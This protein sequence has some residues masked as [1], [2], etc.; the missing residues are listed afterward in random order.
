MI[1]KHAKNLRF[2]QNVKT[3][4]LKK[5]L[6]VSQAA[7]SIGMNKTTLH[8][9]CNGVA[10]RNLESLRRLAKLLEVSVDHLLGEPE[11]SS[12]IKIETLTGDYIVSIRPIQR[13]HGS[14]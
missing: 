13:D 7:L 4:I 11:K 2:S 12:A 8:N 5:G 10:P 3:L 6:S 9:Y 14:A 1:M